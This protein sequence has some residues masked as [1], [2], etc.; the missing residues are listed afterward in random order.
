[1]SDVI[2][3]YSPSK[4]SELENDAGY[5]TQSTIVVNHEIPSSWDTTSISNLVN[6]IQ[7]DTSAIAG[8][9]YIG[10]VSSS[11]LP[12]GLQQA[13]LHIEIT[14]GDVS[15]GKI[16]VFSILS[17][18]VSPYHWERVAAYGRIGNWRAFVTEEDMIKP[19]IATGLPNDSTDTV[20][21]LDALGFTQEEILAAS[22]GKR[23]GVVYNGR[24]YA[25]Q[26]VIY[27]S[28][29]NYVL[30]FASFGLYKLPPAIQDDT[31]YYDECDFYSI[32]RN[33]N[34]VGCNA[35]NIAANNPI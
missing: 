34:Y 6:S 28:D 22:R 2:N 14:A 7:D 10:T 18:D 25:I 8:K 11:G 31:V 13:E 30:R 12:T 23:I 9:S 19:I 16:I 17:E 35:T 33:G 21:K 26:S 24:F 3:F 1:M 32:K 5:V 27:T 15:G 29:T 4:L 20:A